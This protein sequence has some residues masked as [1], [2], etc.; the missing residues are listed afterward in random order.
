MMGFG[1]G[2]GILGLLLMVLF[3][4]GLIF[5]AVWLVRTLFQGAAIH[6]PGSQIE[7]PAGAR[8]TLD[9]RYAQGEI[10]REQYETMR[11]DLGA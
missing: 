1:M 8:E 2:F 9:L 7:K 3:W 5:G 11:K 6:T 4:G 10:T